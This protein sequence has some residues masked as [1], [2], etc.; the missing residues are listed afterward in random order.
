M[1]RAF[2]LPLLLP[3]LVVDDQPIDDRLHERAEAAALGIDLAEIAA[4][5]LQGEF[6]EH[7]VGR[8]LVAQCGQGVAPHRAAVAVEQRLLGGVDGRVI[9]VRLADHRPDGLDAAE[10]EVV[11]HSGNLRM[12]F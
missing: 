1:H 8:V 12:P 11:V 4:D 7:V 10:V 9:A 5:E 6:L 2:L 3:A